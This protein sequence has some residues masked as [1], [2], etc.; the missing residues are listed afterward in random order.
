M[1][2]YLLRKERR[3]D[4]V[5][6]PVPVRYVNDG[7]SVGIE[8]LAPWYHARGELENVNGIGPVPAPQGDVGKPPLSR[9]LVRPSHKRQSE[10]LEVQECLTSRTHEPGCRLGPSTYFQ[11]ILW[12]EQR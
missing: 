1:R 5:R 4:S 9:H 2:Q 6:P 3:E 11:K 7:G 8:Y 10:P 12:T